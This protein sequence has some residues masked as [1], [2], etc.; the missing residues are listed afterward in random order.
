MSNFNSCNRND[1]QV[2]LSQSWVLVAAYFDLIAPILPFVLRDFFGYMH[3]FVR[4]IQSVWF[5]ERVRESV[6][7]NASRHMTSCV[8]YTTR[9]KQ[10]R[11]LELQRKSA[12]MVPVDNDLFPV[13]FLNSTYGTKYFAISTKYAHNRPA[14]SCR[15][16]D[17][18]RFCRFCLNCDMAVGWNMNLLSKTMR[19]YYLLHLLVSDEFNA[20]EIASKQL[21]I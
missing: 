9:T 13:F 7:G 14:E 16:E 15:C 19:S 17:G 20:S 4:T 10:N 11:R 18:V 2:F 3:H 8:I 5:S 1:L 6:Q 12:T 21:L